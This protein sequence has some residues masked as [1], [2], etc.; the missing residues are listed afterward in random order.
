MRSHF[1]QPLLKSAILFTVSMVSAACL[2]AFP[3]ASGV[4][5]TYDARATKTGRLEVQGLPA[6]VVQRLTEIS[7]SNGNWND[8]FTLR[9]DSATAK[10]APPVLGEYS[11]V[12]G[13]LRF[14]PRYPLQAGLS[15]RAAF[16]M[17]WEEGATQRSVTSS[18]GFNIPAPPASAPTVVTQIYPSRNVLPENQLKFYL[19]F[20]APM[21]QGDSY[22]HVR[23]LDGSGK[24][25][26]LPFLELGEE[27]W[28]SAG[29]RLTLLIDPGRIKRGLKPREEVGPV[30]EEGKSYTLVIDSAWPD[31]T[32]KPLQAG[33]RKAFKAGKEDDRQPDLKRWVLS[34]PAKDSREPLVVQF[35]EPLD[36]GMLLRVLTIR[37]SDG[38]PVAGR[39]E[40]D[41]EETRW[42]FRPEHP[43]QAAQYRLIADAT[44]EDLA[45]NT[46]ARPFEVDVVRPIETQARREQMEVSF[47]VRP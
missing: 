12:D 5:I 43:W 23:L 3:P 18:Y 38:E 32:G 9:V 27:L 7:K 29:T 24:A 20:S 4:T 40:I 39:I 45:G 16:Q 6:D 14:E 21:S 25:I 15:Y 37:R 10:D 22:R 42:Q 41:R 11:L 34:A 30:L 17:K 47:E 28:N 13:K 44:L 2:F 36:Q 19:H 31:A 33:F 1:D 8:V 46:L 35:D 26:E